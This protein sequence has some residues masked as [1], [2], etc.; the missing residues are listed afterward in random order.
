[1]SGVAGSAGMSGERA[2]RYW[3]SLRNQRG[4]YQGTAEPCG[5]AVH[6]TPNP[7]SRVT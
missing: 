7:R 5:S 6:E 3:R 2:D 1:M 4:G